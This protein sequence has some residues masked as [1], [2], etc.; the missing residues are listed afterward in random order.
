[1]PIPGKTYQEWIRRFDSFDA[2]ELRAAAEY[3]RSL[4]ARPTFDVVMP[5]HDPPPVF[6][7]AAIASIKLQTYE[8]WRLCIVD[9]GSKLP[10]VRRLLERA[11]AGDSRMQ[12]RRNEVATGIAR[13]TNLALSMGSADFVVFFDH[14]DLLPPHALVTVADWLVRTPATS[15]LY[16]DFDF[17][18]ED[19][20]RSN[21]F[22]KPDYDHDLHLGLNVVTHLTA[23][24]RSVLDKLDGL[25]EGFEG[26]E[27]YDLSLRVVES[28]GEDSIVHVPH[29]LYHWRIVPTSFSRAKTAA[30]VDSARRAV[31]EHCDRIGVPST[32]GG[33]A[34]SLIWNRV[35]ATP[36]VPLTAT[37]VVVSSSVET[38]AE[39]A[40]RLR[41]LTDYSE[42]SF[43][44]SVEA[45]SPGSSRNAVLRE[46]DSDLV[47]F[48][49]GQFL[50][51]EA[52]WLT[53]MASH[54]VHAVTGAV[55]PRVVAADG[56]VK[57]SGIVLGA[58]AQ[59][60][61]IALLPAFAGII[62]ADANYFGRAE[63]AHRA[64]AV[65]GGVI[66]VRKSAVSRAGGFDESIDSPT[67]LDVDLCLRL[68]AA[69]HSVVVCP[70]ALFVAGAD[71]AD[72][73]PEAASESSWA[74]SRAA[75]EA[76]P[77][78][79]PNLSALAADFSL[80]FPP[81][82]SFPWQRAASKER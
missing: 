2:D 72:S 51:R 63:I 38:A 22:F 26:S 17:I 55:G 39:C 59:R 47:A 34:R 13:A 25:R 44:S 74:R 76:D 58:G 49:S 82:V 62:D 31:R 23:Y 77:Y 80:A 68:R 79:N 11:V 10:E 40:G 15:L 7:E 32:I 9:D 30:A 69:G 71:A 1:V 19:G 33:T 75:L 20:T 50:P 16:S 56:T 3:G 60:G 53:E 42:A 27:D 64:S 54:F 14:D 6:L 12:L 70:Y 24:R 81:R 57:Q 4:V 8:D 73:G 67:L 61:G 37:V 52:S 18:D 41:A 65:S 45:A 35:R 5:V 36:A 46:A 21:P 29:V 28:C 48:V 78:Y 43:L 66:V